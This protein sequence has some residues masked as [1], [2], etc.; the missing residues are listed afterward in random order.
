MLSQFTQ[1]LDALLEYPV[2]SRIRRNH[3][4][5]HATLH[6][7]AERFPKTPMAGHSTASGF[8]LVGELST[9]A[10]Q[11]AVDEALRRLRAGDAKLAVHPNCGTNFVTAGT[12]AGLAGAGSMLGV[13]KGKWDKLE[14]LPLAAVLATLAL[15]VSL[16]LGMKLQEK[17]TTSGQPGDLEITRI[18]ATR[19]GKVTI[20][21]VFTRG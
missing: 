9:D 21:Q 7:L 20:H 5:E 16:P 17:V 14:R 19:H 12:L 4:L 6:V 11:E 2:L 10:V 18:L 1:G 15:M 13:G 8:R 3:G